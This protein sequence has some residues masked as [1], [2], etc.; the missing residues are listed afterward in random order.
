MQ[1]HPAAGGG[2]GRAVAGAAH[3]SWRGQGAGAGGAAAAALG[4]LQ[5]HVLL[6]DRQDPGAAPG[7][8]TCVSHA[9]SSR[10]L[11]QVPPALS[12][13][14]FEAPGGLQLIKGVRMRMRACCTSCLPALCY[15]QALHALCAARQ[16]RCPT[17]LRLTACHYHA[18]TQC[19]PTPLAWYFHQLPGA[20]LRSRYLVRW[21]HHIDLTHRCGHDQ[22]TTHAANVASR[23]VLHEAQAW[24]CAASCRSCDSAC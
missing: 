9:S 15:V 19:L 10:C 17:W 6:G 2:L 24:F 7:P 13:R 23:C 4:A 14:G 5:A 16:A 22:E 3:A 11:A 12:D 20:R 8:W 21:S 18:A 1:G